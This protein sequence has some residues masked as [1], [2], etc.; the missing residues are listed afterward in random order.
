MTIWHEKLG[1][2]RTVWS[3][4]RSTPRKHFSVRVYCG[5][6]QRGNFPRAEISSLKNASHMTWEVNVSMRLVSTPSVFLLLQNC[7]PKSLFF[8]KSSYF[9]WP[10]KSANIELCQKLSVLQLYWKS[11]Q[12]YLS[13]IIKAKQTKFSQD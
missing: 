1:I 6:K 3:F 9:S 10:W 2:L 8:I 11:S 4:H 5:C 13:G 12:T 7:I